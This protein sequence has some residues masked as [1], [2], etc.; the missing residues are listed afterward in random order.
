MASPCGPASSQST[1]WVPRAALSRGQVTF[2]DLASGVTSA[3]FS[4]SDS[5]KAIPRFKR[6]EDGS[7]TFIVKEHVIWDT[8]VCVAIFD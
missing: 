6:K 4:E 2:S 5:Y 3:M 7:P 8:Y 1:G